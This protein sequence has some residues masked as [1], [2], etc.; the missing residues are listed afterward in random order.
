M[1]EKKLSFEERF[2]LNANEYSNVYIELDMFSIR[3]SNRLLGKKIDTVEKLLMCSHDTLANIKGFG[4]GC[5]KEVYDYIDTLRKS[6][7]ASVVENVSA[8]VSYE[9]PLYYKEHVNSILDDNYDF[10]HNREEEKKI[11]S[12]LQ[13]ANS[14]VDRELLHLCIR[15]PEYMM[16]LSFE[17]SFFGVNFELKN[18]IMSQIPERRK[19][20]KV[21]NYI[22]AMAE[23]E[24]KYF[25]K[26]LIKSKDE[27]LEHFIRCNYREFVNNKNYL[28]KFIKVCTFDLDVLINKF[29]NEI[30]KD[31]RTYLIVKKRAEGN[32]LEEVGAVFSVTRERI[33]QIERKSGIKLMNWIKANKILSKIVADENG[34][35]IFWRE[36]FDVF[37]GQYS[38]IVW[39]LLRTYCDKIAGLSYD[40]S[41]GFFIY[42]DE[43]LLINMQTYVD[44]LPTHFNEMQLN[45]YLQIASNI[46]GYPIDMLMILID[47]Q[48]KKTGDVYHTSR[49]TLGSIYNQILSK[50][51]PYGVHIY[52]EREINSFREYIK[53]EFGDINSYPSDRAIIA[54]VTAIGVLCDRGTYCAKKEK[55]ISQELRDDI[56]NYI[57]NS[58]PVIFSLSTIYDVF[59][60]RLNK[61]NVN[62]RYYLQGIIKE[63]FSNDFVLTKDYISKDPNVTTVYTEI[64]SLIK[65]S[66]HPVTKRQISQAFPGITDIVLNM[67]VSDTDIINLFGEYIHSSKLKLDDVDIKYIDNVLKKTFTDKDFIHCKDIYGFI[68]KDNPNLLTSNGIYQAFGL[69]SLLEYLYAD[70]L[71]FMRP[72]IGKQGVQ[73]TRTLTQM[74]EMV[75]LSEKIYLKDIIYFAKENHFQIYSILDFAVSCNDTHLLLNNKE[76]A[77]FEYIGVDEYIANEVENII[78]NEIKG[79]TYIS[80]MQCIHKFPKINVNWTE[81]LIYTLLC[82]WG[83]NVDVTVTSTTF[84]YA[85]AVIAPKGDMCTENLEKRINNS[86]ENMYLPDDLENIDDLI[87]DISFDEL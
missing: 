77:S 71:E 44:G 39:F 36:K 47:R 21:I 76:L 69:Y 68:S 43:S 13:D 33:R 52:D 5:F 15:E 54:R 8:D 41:I 35:N 59:K 64:I 29:F 10:S 67:A 62:N 2:N 51:Y 14:C 73:I 30:L 7:A 19:K 38:S 45:A 56:Y 23:G 84:R 1:D 26:N 74:Y 46:H 31:E 9:L 24:E 16:A 87:I 18:E 17:L 80:D 60:E 78:L 72:Y 57:M 66:R 50:Y 53:F 48:Y 58:E 34:N 6:N 28:S 49:L 83:K 81:W 86:R 4:A 55:Y 42:G 20:N 3:V 85:Q 79:T 40:K 12:K 22:N 70:K 82:K 75:E 25:L 63:L 37:F 65:K 61:E 32:T 11:I 27:E